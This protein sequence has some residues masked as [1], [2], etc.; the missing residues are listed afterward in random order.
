M[1]DLLILFA[2]SFLAA[3][4]F[5]A[6]SEALLAYMYLNGAHSAAL[7]ITIA[8][9]GNVLGAC[10]NWFLGWHL[11]C[12]KGKAWFPISEKSMTRAEG[13]YQRFG[14]W[15]LL[16]S[17]VPFIGDPLTFIAGIFRMNFMLFLV[18]VTTG[19]LA[20]YIAVIM[21]VAQ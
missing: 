8:T 1:H 13:F 7:L 5:P 3:T 18:L 20:R 12:F 14:V 4:I 10:V 9:L 6:Q 16:F 21:F 19:K 11:I 17:W 2:S 15:T